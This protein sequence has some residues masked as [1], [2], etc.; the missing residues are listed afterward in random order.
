MPV[1]QQ[2]ASSAL[3]FGGLNTAKAAARTYPE[4]PDCLNVR[5]DLNDQLIKRTGFTT[6]NSTAMTN[7]NAITGVF[8]FNRRDTTTRYTIVGDKDRLWVAPTSGAWTQLAASMGASVT[9]Y[10]DFAVF[11]NELI[12]VNGVTAPQVSDGTAGGT[13]SLTSRTWQNRTSSP[14]AQGFTCGM[15]TI[16]GTGML[17][18]IA[19][20]VSTGV[21]N[22]LMQGYDPYTDA[23]KALTRSTV[24]RSSGQSAAAYGKLY[25][26]AGVTTGPV[27]TGTA[28]VYSPET[29]T[30]KAITSPTTGVD[31]GT[32]WGIN[33]AIYLV[34]GSTNNTNAGSI[35]TNQKYDPATDTW[36]AQTSITTA[37]NLAGS[38]TISQIGYI[39]GGKN[40]SST[41]LTTMEGYNPFSNTIISSPASLGT[42]TFAM[43]GS[44]GYGDGKG[45][46]TGG[47][48]A[49]TPIST[50]QSYDAIA[51][52]WT[53]EISLGTARAGHAACISDYWIYAHGNSTPA[54]TM[55]RMNSSPAAP[56]AFYVESF[57]GYVIMGRTAAFPSRVFYS[58][59]GDARQWDAFAFFDVNPDDGEWITGMFSFGGRFYVTK[60]NTIYEIP[61]TVLDPEEGDEDILPLYNVPGCV[62]NRSI[63]VT[64]HGVYY[65]AKDGIRLFDGAK[66]ED[67]ATKFIGPTLDSYVQT[68]DKY[69]QGLWVKKYNE[70]WFSFTSTGSTHDRLVV[71]NYALQK[72]TIFS[73][74]NCEAMGLVEDSAGNDQFLFGTGDATDGKLYLAD[75]TQADNAGAINAYYKTGWFALEPTTE[76]AGRYCYIYTKRSGNWNLSVDLYRNFNASAKVK[77][78]G[79]ADQGVNINLLS[80]TYTPDTDLYFPDATDQMARIDMLMDGHH[81][82]MNFSNANASQDFA[83]YGAIFKGHNVRPAGMFL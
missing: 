78:A 32:C 62:S 59:A 18:D 57:K 20:N 61:F 39:V 7:K 54:A 49:G 22:G 24:A 21:V 74:M 37:R 31:I 42:A 6:Y 55:E 33:N 65:L 64:D 43:A 53:S 77:D 17:Y 14:Q 25:V 67:I 69:C 76:A 82:Q 46:M 56:T 72:W 68:R 75:S 41:R 10:W 27:V 58:V 3:V 83:I 8:G 73:G 40:T 52:T 9:D 2:P 71:Y 12:A 51:D 36:A 1:R 19:G 13:G 16:D 81:F 66:S 29:D 80:G 70:V 30:W 60:L 35:A 23:W 5:W 63:V 50:V 4:S 26:P 44:N 45:Y 15:R 47:D 79:G 48:T 11:N 34:A 38:F 28:E